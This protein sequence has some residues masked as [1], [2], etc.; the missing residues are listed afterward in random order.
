MAF[1][2]K[3]TR[4]YMDEEDIAGAMRILSDAITD[5]RERLEEG[6]DVW[7]LGPNMLMKVGAL[8]TL[9]VIRANSFIDNG[10]RFALLLDS[11]IKEIR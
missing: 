8:L 11:K 7:N 3:T 1:S 9:E 5:A 10:K 6:E 2:R 4:Y